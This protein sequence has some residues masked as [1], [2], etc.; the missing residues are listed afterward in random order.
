MVQIAEMKH[1]MKLL[2][3][4]TSTINYFGTEAKS[5]GDRRGQWIDRDE[6][7]H[8]LHLKSDDRERRDR[9]I[10]RLAQRIRA[11]F[12]QKRGRK[13]GMWKCLMQTKIWGKENENPTWFFVFFLIASKGHFHQIKHCISFLSIF[14]LFL[15]F[16][17]NYV[18]YMDQMLIFGPN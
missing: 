3:L 15:G 9:E 4:L 18:T 16:G 10:T 14:R 2:N 13:W 11:F 8:C 1:K 6:K 17:L 12:G 5:N 7:C